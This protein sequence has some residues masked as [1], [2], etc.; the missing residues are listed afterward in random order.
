MN[1][2]QLKCLL[3]RDLASEGVSSNDYTHGYVDYDTAAWLFDV[4]FNEPCDTYF[5]N[6]DEYSNY[7]EG[8]PERARWAC[9]D[10]NW[11][12]TGG[13]FVNYPDNIIVRHRYARPS[14]IQV[15]EWF[16]NTFFHMTIDISASKISVKNLYIRCGDDYMLESFEYHP[17]QPIKDPYVVAGVAVK[18]IIQRAKLGYQ[19]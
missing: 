15:L 8:T 18:Q 7:D 6:V 13:K 2:K 16:E 11:E 19:M 17:G 4:H 3:I 12:I 5:H 1:I 14:Y 10:D 9:R